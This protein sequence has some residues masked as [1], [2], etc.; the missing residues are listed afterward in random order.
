MSGYLK[1][2]TNPIIQAFLPR[3][4]N[5]EIQ[6]QNVDEA[7]VY[8]VELEFRKRLDFI[9]SAL[10]DLKFSTNVSFI[11][12]EVDIPGD[13]NDPDTEAGII[14]RFNPEKGFTR[15]FAGQS[16]FL[17]N[18]ALNYANSELGLDAL[19][20]F[21]IFGRRLAFNSESLTPDVYET[22]I[23]QLDFSVSKTLTERFSAKLSLQNILNQNFR[24]V[25]EYRG[26]DYDIRRFRQGVTIGV[27]LSYRI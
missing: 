23:P 14:N 21:N 2:F 24:Q 8:G 9:S 15:P 11:Y 12:S 4:A 17:L 6:F 19:L 16:P 27:S 5:P 13:P 18:M 26:R 1:N 22:P 25:M 20:A 10:K 3:A 7:I